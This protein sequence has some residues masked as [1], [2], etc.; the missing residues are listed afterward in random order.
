MNLERIAEAAWPSGPVAG[1]RTRKLQ[2]KA[3]AERAG[4][5]ST[6]SHTGMRGHSRDEGNATQT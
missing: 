1:D 6:I 2:G 3:C 5:V 4:S